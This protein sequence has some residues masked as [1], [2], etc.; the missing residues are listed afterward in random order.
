MQMNVHRV[1]RYCFTLAA[2]AIPSALSAQAFGLNELGTCA[3]GRGF[4]NVS[5]ACKD[6]SSIY[7][8]PAATTQ[9]TGWSFYGGI[10][11][12][13]VNGQFEQDSTGRVFE[14]NPP[15]AYVPH[16]YLNYRAPNSRL[17]YGLGFYVP[18]GLTSQWQDDFPGRFSAQ[19]A[20]IKTFYIQ[21]N[22]AYRLNDNWSVGGGPIIGHSSVELIQGVDLSQQTLPTGATFGSLGIARYTQFATARLE[23]SAVG[24]GGQIGIAGKLTKNWNVGARYMLPITFKYD[25]ADATFTQVNTNLI[26]GGDVPNPANPTGPPLIPRGT[27]VDVLVQPQFASGGSLVAQ[28]VETEIKHPQQFQVGFEYTGFANWSLEADYAF[29]GWK[30]FKELPVTFQGPASAS[31][32]TLI[33]DYNNSSSI[34]LGAEYAFKSDI[35]ARAGFAGVSRAAPATTV[36]PLLPDQERANYA[37]GL[38]VPVISGFML[39]AGYLRVQTP[40]RR[41]RIDERT[42]RSQTAASLNTG[43][44][45][46]TANI[47]LFSLKAS[48]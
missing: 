24:F 16:A 17:A 44:Y 31:S 43:V 33:E 19:K 23:G 38:T 21:P 29:V 40:G 48:F 4:A 9:L 27:P 14:A 37:L 47:F 13:P 45:D 32:R 28:K 10:A 7:W 15:T 26:I 8:S 3:L 6:A 1:T 46:L 18:Y 35:R 22:I 30:S 39:D 36:T 41:G 25:D 20:S 5:G 12:I 2:L 34:R 11:I 42:S